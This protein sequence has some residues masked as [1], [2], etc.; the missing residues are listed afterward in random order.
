MP[1]AASIRECVLTIF[2][3]LLPGLASR[4]QN[5]ALD[6]KQWNYRYFMKSLSPEIL[7][8]KWHFWFIL[9]ASMWF[10]MNKSRGICVSV[11]EGSLKMHRSMIMPFKTVANSYMA[12]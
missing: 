4:S 6:R 9:V 3:N 5:I 8:S 1:W 7:V 10:G 12:A 2:W 11:L